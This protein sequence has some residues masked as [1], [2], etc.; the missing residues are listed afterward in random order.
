MN[1]LT[2]LFIVFGSFNRPVYNDYCLTGLTITQDTT[3]IEYWRLKAKSAIREAEQQKKI[4]EKLASEVVNLKKQLE[5]CK[6][7]EE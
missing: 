5:K 2:V 3:S 1:A 4:S 6:K 7:S